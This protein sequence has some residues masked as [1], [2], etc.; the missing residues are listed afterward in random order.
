MPRRRRWP[1]TAGTT[2]CAAM[3]HCC[4]AAAGLLHVAA[5]LCM[6]LSAFGLLGQAEADRPRPRSCAG[7]D[8]ALP[9]CAGF[10]ASR[11]TRRDNQPSRRP[12]GS[13]EHPPP[14]TT[15][16]DLTT[17]TTQTIR[18]CITTTTTTTAAAASAPP[19]TR[20]RLRPTRGSGLLSDGGSLSPPNHAASAAAPDARNPNLQPR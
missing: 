6:S 4:W 16:L 1:G 10:P 11:P 9:P 14:L 8:S 18:G 5:G 12:H 17:T 13:R 3:L 7:C 19:C 20:P 2:G 15:H